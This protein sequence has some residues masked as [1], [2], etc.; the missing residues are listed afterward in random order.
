[1]QVIGV[2]HCRTGTKSLQTALNELGYKTYHMIEL[3][4][5]PNRDLFF[6]KMAYDGVQGKIGSIFWLIENIMPQPTIPLL[7]FGKTCFAFTPTQNF[8]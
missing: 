7:C 8:F 5:N 3:I 2:G 1:M 6:W 4:N